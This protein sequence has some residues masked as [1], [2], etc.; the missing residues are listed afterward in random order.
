MTPRVLGILNLTPDS[1]SDGGRFASVAQAA[2]AAHVMIAAGAAMVDIGGESTRPG[3]PFVSE[4]EELARVAPVIDA[5]GGQVPFSI[6]TRRAAVMAYALDH[7]A[8]LVNDVSALTHDPAA[9]S[10]VAA[11]GCGVVLMHMV[12]TPATMQVAPA[13]GDVVR[14]VGD[15]LAERVEACVAAG[16]VRTNITVDPGIGFGKTLDHNLALLRGLRT[17]G[18]I[19]PVMLGASRKALIGKLTGA[20]TPDRL[21]GSLALALHGAA[22]GCA[23][24]RVHDVA[25][26]VQ[27]LR[28][29]EAL[30]G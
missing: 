23:W 17:L 12:G 27:A 3:A 8:S 26:T 28:V 7:G 4:A 14:E 19:A 18:E 29:W 9:L 21:P 2:D 13:Y 5:L 11:R 30:R 20:E 25:E 22:T 6:D 16:I 1:F 15:W 10:L 24:V